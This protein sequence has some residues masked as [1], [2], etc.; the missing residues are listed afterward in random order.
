MNELHDRFA[1]WLREG[2][3]DEIARD[4]AVHASGCQQCLRRAEAIDALQA[5]DPGRASPPPPDATGAAL[6]IPRFEP[7][8]QAIG[9]GAVV[10]LAL[11]VGLAASRF[12]VGTPS[13]N[14]PATTDT[15][16]PAGR[17]LGGGPTDDASPS[18]SVSPSPRGGLISTTPDPSPAIRPSPSDAAPQPVPVPPPAVPPPVAS[19]TPRPATAAP[20][21]TPTPSPTPSPTATPLPPSPSPTA[22]QATPS[23]SASPSQVP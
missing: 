23:P 11:V 20:T 15:P 9:G 8:A 17:V 19:L 21:P 10:L 18:A 16:T 3:R 7:S 12:L 1:A 5:I 13:T 22:P 6:S 14:R 4:V 2:A